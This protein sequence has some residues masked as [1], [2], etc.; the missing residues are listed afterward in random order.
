[1]KI[2]LKLLKREKRIQD[3]RPFLVVP[4][5]KGQIRFWNEIFKMPYLRDVIVLCSRSTSQE[6]LDFLKEINIDYIIAGE[7]QADLTGAL[8]KLNSEY[9]VE[10][11]RVDSGGYFKRSSSKRWFS[12]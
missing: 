8:D 11:I 7:D 9:R 6:Y 12:R 1:M 3:T 5:S 4:D 2:M 10:K